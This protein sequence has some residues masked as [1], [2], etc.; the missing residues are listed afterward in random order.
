MLCG[1]TKIVERYVYGAI[2]NYLTEH[3]LLFTA[4]S[5]FRPAHSR[6]TPPLRM[7]DMW[8]AAMG[9]GEVNVVIVLDL[10]NAFDLISRECLLEK[11]RIYQCDDNS[12]KV[13][14][15]EPKKH[16]SIMLNDQELQQVKQHK[17][18]GVVV[19]ENRQWREHCWEDNCDGL[20][21]CPG[22]SVQLQY[23][24]LRKIKPCLSTGHH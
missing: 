16:Q 23:N 14:R 11:L 21:S 6:G 19:G 22:E 15:S 9:R 18:I 17:V 2:Y 8:A 12:S 3:N 10:R 20:A 13:I 24:Y 7:I 1:V 5:G 4:Q